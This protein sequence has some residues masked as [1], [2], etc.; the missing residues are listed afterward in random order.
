MA[1][2]FLKIPILRGVE[3]GKNGHLQ[4]P[5][6]RS[7]E[8]VFD[9]DAMLSAQPVEVR[10]AKG[11]V[12]CLLMDSG[13]YVFANMSMDEFWQQLDEVVRRSLAENGGYERPRNIDYSS[14]GQA[15]DEVPDG[16]VEAEED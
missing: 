1:I 13:E 10:G 3:K 7:A 5:A 9:A 8:L 12:I 4:V 2:P 15:A 6:D 11:H 16:E 14:W